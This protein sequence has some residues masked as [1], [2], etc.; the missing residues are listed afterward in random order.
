MNIENLRDYCLSLPFSEEKFP[1]DDE[2][3]VFCVGGKIFAL[4][5]L[6]NA[7]RV[8]LKCEPEQAIMLREAYEGIIPGWHM[9]KKHWN[10][11]FFDTDV[12]DK[13]L[14]ELV[15]NSYNLVFE[16]LPKRLKE[17]LK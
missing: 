12:S 11:V 5:D 10:T 2:T 7:T 6:G 17:T 14:L 3:L 15:L 13:L 9:N 4:V 1:F 16:R 8:N